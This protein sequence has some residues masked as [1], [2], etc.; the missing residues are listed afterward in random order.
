MLTIHICY[1]IV[2]QWR[3]RCHSQ[4]LYRDLWSGRIRSS[5]GSASRD[6]DGCTH[7]HRYVLFLSLEDQD[8]NTLQ[9]NYSV[10]PFALAF[11]RRPA[12]IGAALTLLV[13][14]IGAACTVNFSGHLA[15]RMI[16][17]LAAGAT[18]SVSLSHPS[19]TLKVLARHEGRHIHHQH[20]SIAGYAIFPG[21]EH[22]NVEGTPFLVSLWGFPKCHPYLSHC[23][24]CYR[25]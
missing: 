11:G 17:A 1:G 5:N 3:T 2:G 18:E 23:R 12:F 24:S 16:Q 20:S 10:M 8:V 7:W 13:S 19:S 22:R 15:A 14:V 9:G 25:S 6:S 4:H 21:I